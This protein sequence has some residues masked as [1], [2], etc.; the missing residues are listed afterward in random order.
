[1]EQLMDFRTLLSLLSTSA[2]IA[3]GI[4]AG[5]QL[6]HINKQRSRDSAMQMLH[7]FQTREFMDG[8]DIIFNLPIGL[9]KKEIEERVGERMVS[10]LVVL[11][12]F[13]S[14]GI[15]VHRREISL[16]LIDDFFSGGI[17]L[18]WKKFENYIVGV[19]EFNNRETYA[20]WVQC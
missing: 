15:L 17:V 1:M 8:Y 5:V 11:G 20:E 4:F 13:E 9:S 12:T 19:R 18:A 14:M 6:R 3:G 10:V 2:I 7:S 16:E